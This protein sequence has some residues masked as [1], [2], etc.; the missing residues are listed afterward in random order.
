MQSSHNIDFCHGKLTDCTIEIKKRCAGA[1]PWVECEVVKPAL[2][3]S[4]MGEY[5][6]AEDR[7]TG[8]HCAVCN[9]YPRLTR[10]R[11][12]LPGSNEI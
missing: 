8:F 5:L 4:S 10:E 12:K 7:A 11:P 6:E 3:M 2:R 9:V 1:Y